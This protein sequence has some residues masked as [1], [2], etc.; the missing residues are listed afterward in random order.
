[1]KSLLISSSLLC[2]LLF[3]HIQ[4][5]KEESKEVDD[6]SIEDDDIEVDEETKEKAHEPAHHQREQVDEDEFDDPD[7]LNKSGKKKKNAKKPASKK[8]E[9]VYP[10]TNETNHPEEIITKQKIILSLHYEILMSSILIIFILTCIIGK[11][12]NLK[13]ANK[14]LE[15]NKKFF[16][17]NYAHLGGNKEYNPKNTDLLI[18]ESY[19]Q[20]KFFASGRVFLSWMMVNI[21][22]KKRQDLLSMLSSIFLFGEKD[23]II[24][25]ASLLPST[26]IPVVFAICKKKEAKTLKRNY[27]E[28]DL[29]TEPDAPSYM[30]TNLVLLTES[31]EFTFKFFQ[32]GAFKKYYQKIEDYIEMVFFTD[33]RGYGK[34]KNALVTTFDITRVKGDL[35]EAM[36]DMTHFTHILI[37]LLCSSSVKANY[38]KEADN[39][40]REYD[41]KKSR[42]LAEKNAEEIKNKKEELKSQKLNKPLTREQAQKLEE[43]EKKEQLK[44]QKKKMFKI[45]K[46]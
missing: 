36:S 10:P 24:Y 26:E 4:C 15:Q 20:Y 18:K 32:N 44:H 6:L 35:N 43:K 27:D 17:D 41:A 3:S 14:W 5:T 23:K 39:R 38:K 12:T 2:L 19:N 31:P 25:E 40:R 8:E 11:A 7:L 34:E 46:N 29:F 22:L 30:N 9:V 33:R 13:I 21:E 28:L 45:I 16:E 42:E 37:D 1:M